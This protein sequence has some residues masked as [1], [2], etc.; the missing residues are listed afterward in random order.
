MLDGDMFLNGGKLQH[1]VKN[2]K[3][4]VNYMCFYFLVVIIL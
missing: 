4:Y 3:T 1:E 2:E